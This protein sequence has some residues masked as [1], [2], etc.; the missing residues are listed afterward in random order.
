M[1][2]KSTIYFH[3]ECS[4]KK[5]LHSLQYAKKDIFAFFLNKFYVV[6]MYY[7]VTVILMTFVENAETGKFLFLVILKLLHF[8]CS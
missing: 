4:F 5:V 6:V 7:T 8:T 1:M 3:Y 2:Q